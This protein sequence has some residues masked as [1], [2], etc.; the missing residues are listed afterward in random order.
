MSLP[1]ASVLVEELDAELRSTYGARVN[2]I[3]GE[4]LARRAIKVKEDWAKELSAYSASTS[5]KSLGHV[6]D[7]VCARHG[8]SRRTFYRILSGQNAS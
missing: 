4:D 3:H 6:R 5:A 8:I 2:Y 7:G 1:E